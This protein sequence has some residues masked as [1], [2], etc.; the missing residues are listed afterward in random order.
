MTWFLLFVNDIYVCSDVSVPS[1]MP[2]EVSKLVKDYG[3]GS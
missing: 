1:G 3:D 2:V